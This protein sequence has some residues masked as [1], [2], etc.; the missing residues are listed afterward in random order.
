[1]MGL[2]DG[3]ITDVPGITRTEALKLCGNGVVPQQCA[4]AVRWL[5]DVRANSTTPTLKETHK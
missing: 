1:M 5:L 2:P 4:E 3:W